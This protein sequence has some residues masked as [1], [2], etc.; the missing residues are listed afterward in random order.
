[1]LSTLYSAG[2]RGV[3]GFIVTVECDVRDRQE[4]F[5]IVGLPDA[6]IKEAK[7]RIRSGIENIGIQFPDA[8]IVINMAPADMKKT[9]TAYDLAMVIGILRS[10]GYVV[11]EA[12]L[13]KRCFIGELSLSG[14][15]R[16]VP[17]VLSMVLAAREKG[18][19]EVFVSAENAPEASVVRRYA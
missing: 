16:G 15:I 14:D 18:I 11:A 13:K 2:L 1:M 9:G 12:D 10:S 7:E 19:K 4:H 17:G 5:E 3:D 8:A 6:A